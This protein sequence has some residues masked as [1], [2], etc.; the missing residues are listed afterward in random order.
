MHTVTA[1]INFC[2][3]LQGVRL[4]YHAHDTSRDVL[5]ITPHEATVSDARQLSS[6]PSLDVEGFT[7][8]PHK[9][10]VSDFHHGD[11]AEIKAVYGGEVRQLLLDLTGADEVEMREIGI[12]R[13]G[14]RS[15]DSGAT[16]SS[17]TEQAGALT[18]APPTRFVHID[19][20]DGTAA[21]WIGKATPPEGKRIKRATHLNVWR[22]LTPPPQDVPLAVC[23]A[24]TLAPEHVSFA[25]VMFDDPSDGRILGS[26]E[27]L[28]VGYGRTQRWWF[29]ADMQ[30][31][32]VLVFKTNDTDPG[33]SH[34]VAHA[35]FDNPLCP[36]GTEP[37]ASFEMRGTAFW[38]E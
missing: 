26:F 8:V 3:P 38:Y 29:Y 9:S 7:L 23:D 36:A 17:G 19:I 34:A 10:V 25:D 21:A 33:V 15:M 35:A 22:V 30:P 32:E 20:S 24:R 1:R 18:K 31:D 28:V 16:K 27:A 4:K 37:R 14:E 5:N 12:I 6:P 13:S 11:P 2:E